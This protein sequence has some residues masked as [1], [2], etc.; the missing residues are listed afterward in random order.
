MEISRLRCL[1]HDLDRLE[2]TEDVIYKRIYK[3]LVLVQGL[4]PDL[5]S[6]V[7]ETGRRIFYLLNTGEYE[8]ES[9]FEWKIGSRKF[10]Q[11]K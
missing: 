9:C 8:A 6:P 10:T 4:L 11:I 3:R 2:M 7:Y 1:I 5:I